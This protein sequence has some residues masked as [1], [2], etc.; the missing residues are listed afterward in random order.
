MR[1]SGTKKIRFAQ[2]ETIQLRVGK[3]PAERL[4]WGLTF[5]QRDLDALT[6]GEWVDLRLELNSFA[7]FLVWWDRIPVYQREKI[8]QQYGHSLHVMP[9]T[10]PI[11]EEE[12]R[13]TQARFRGVLE[14][15]RQTN[16]TTIGPMTVKYSV[17]LRKTPPQK[18]LERV[19]NLPDRP[20]RDLK[21]N[22][23]RSLSALLQQAMPGFGTPIMQ[24]HGGFENQALVKFAE[25]LAGHSAM[26]RTC[27][28][29]GC[30]RWFVARR[31]NQDY[32]SKACQTLVTT[33]RHRKKKREAAKASAKKKAS[34]KR[35]AKKTIQKR[36]RGK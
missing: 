8:H 20:A 35:Q 29:E 7:T 26:V 2:H 23:V 31:L 15:L 24:V 11:T 4:R 28:R 13:K 36:R 9:F 30:S 3:N 12:A 17:A 33:W 10:R 1:T 22:I 25:L 34:R 32:C 16:R 14:E 27:P 6:N 18:F 21:A 19:F 5:A